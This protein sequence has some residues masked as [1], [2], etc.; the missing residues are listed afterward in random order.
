MSDFVI[1]IINLLMLL[2]PCLIFGGVFFLI[3]VVFII[4]LKLFIKK[5]ECYLHKGHAR[6]EPIERAVLRGYSAAAYSMRDECFGR[7]CTG[8]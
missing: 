3:L 5:I 4:M 2:L 7:S 8:L 6:S 1:V